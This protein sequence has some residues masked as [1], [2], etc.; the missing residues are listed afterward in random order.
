[1]KLR[2]DEWARAA[3]AALEDAKVLVE[4]VPDEHTRGLTKANLDR[5][6][7]EFGEGTRQLD[8]L[9]AEGAAEGLT[10]H[11]QYEEI[12]ADIRAEQLQMAE[13][14]KQLCE[15]SRT[16]FGDEDTTAGGPEPFRRQAPLPVSWLARK[17]SSLSI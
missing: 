16:L 15:L 7:Q 5:Q 8:T 11:H 1:M 9:L 4:S 10:G 14:V 2:M 17:A 3:Q 6:V 13:A 12:C